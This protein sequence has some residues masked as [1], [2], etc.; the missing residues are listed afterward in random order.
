M[1]RFVCMN[2]QH[3][4]SSCC[5]AP[6]RRYGGRRRQC[7]A[8][9]RTWRIYRKRR[10]RKHRRIDK[11]LL[12]RTLIEKQTL[13]QQI[14]I[15]NHRSAAALRKRFRK[16]LTWFTQQ[17]RID[18]FPSG[19]LILV[20]D[21]LWYRFAKK[22][23]VLYLMAIKPVQGNKAILLNPVLLSGKENYENWKQAIRTIP[24][25]IRKQIKAFVSD[26]FRGSKKLAKQNK[27]IHQRCHFHL[28]A[29]LQVRRGRKKS[30]LIGRNIREAIYL[31]IR[32][33]LETPD[34]QHL[35]F[36]KEHLK[37]LSIHSD[38]PRKMRMIAHEFLKEINSFR[39]YL[40]YPKLNLPTTTNTV[41]ATGK[42]IRGFSRN[43][44]TPKSLQLWV[45]AFRRLRPIVTCN[46]K[47]NQPN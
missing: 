34:K 29:Q 37:R 38:C 45:T 43:L 21:G 5:R 1:R 10:G 23:W 32:Q 28:I 22:D 9:H 33:S 39:A 30:N 2:T 40:L 16:A 14:R 13:K 46:G 35:K 4:K 18:F 8:C 24:P 41:E 3:T 25:E 19:R 31:G 42:V 47:K 44:N 7:P 20:G 12:V 27:W 17:P 11:N 26:G 36:L 6:I 15:Y